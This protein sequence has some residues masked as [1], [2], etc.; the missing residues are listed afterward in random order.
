MKP[1]SSL[2]YL[3]SSLG[4]D[5]VGSREAQGEYLPLFSPSVTSSHI[6][7]TVTLE[8]T[9]SFQTFWRTGGLG[10]DWT[11]ENCMARRKRYLLLGEP[12]AGEPGGLPKVL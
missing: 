12:C 9:L 6:Y 8:G 7:R 2:K 11:S 1:T 4:L 5:R 10:Q 3:E